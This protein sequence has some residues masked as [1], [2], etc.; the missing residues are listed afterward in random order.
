MAM[1]LV[2]GAWM[3]LMQSYQALSLKL[4]QQQSERAQIR[5]EQDDFEIGV[6]AM[7]ISHEPSR[8]SSGA[9]LMP[10]TS[11]STAQVQR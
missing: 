10:A 5:R 4:A 7:G 3:T 1:S 6:M 8:M 11:Q 2:L 9:H